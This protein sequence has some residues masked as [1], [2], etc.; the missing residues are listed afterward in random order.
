MLTSYSGAVENWRVGADEYTEDFPNHN[1]FS[2]LVSVHMS[3][4]L[5]V[6]FGDAVAIASIVSINVLVVDEYY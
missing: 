3:L 2:D 4:G 1:Y 5:A 6:Q